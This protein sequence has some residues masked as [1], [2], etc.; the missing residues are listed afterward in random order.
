TTGISTSQSSSNGKSVSTT[1]SFNQT[2]ATSDD[3]SW[4]GGDA[5]LY[6]GTSANQ[7]YGTYDELLTSTT[8]NSSPIAVSYVQGSQTLSRNLYPKVNK[9]LYF[10]ESPEKTV[11]I[12]TQHHILNEIIPQYLEF[13]RKIEAGELVENKDGVL[14]KSAYQSSV[15][16]WRKII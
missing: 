5:D 16:L 8:P 13:I 2:I 7:F 9:A 6:I 15:N 1:Y 12:Y 14:S 3:P 4:T 11:F 10:N